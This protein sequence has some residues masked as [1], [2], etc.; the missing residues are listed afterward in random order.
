MKCGKTGHRAKEC[1]GK[2]FCIKCNKEEHRA[3]QI[4]CPYFKR[5]VEIQA[6]KTIRA[7]VGQNAR[8]NA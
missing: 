6:Q 1:N 3:D 4:K 2:P 8:N 7:T 5:L